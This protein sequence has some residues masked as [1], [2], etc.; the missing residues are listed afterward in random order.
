MPNGVAVLIAVEAWG[1]SSQA[2]LFELLTGEEGVLQVLSAPH[3]QPTNFP[4]TDC[5]G[6]GK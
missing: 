1:H 4:L 2:K 5:H 3:Y 6:K